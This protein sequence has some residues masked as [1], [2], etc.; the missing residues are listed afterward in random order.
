MS[1]HTGAII[2]AI[3]GG[4]LAA[5][6]GMGAGT[7][8]STPDRNIGASLITGGST[9]AGGI[10]LSLPFALVSS[11]PAAFVCAGVAALIGVTIGALRKRG[12]RGYIE[13]GI[14]LAAAAVV[15]ISAGVLLG[16]SA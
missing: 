13:T 3:I 10:S 15:T 16:G 11:R 4:T 14:I 2:P 9:A 8:L 1:G 7:W 12:R 6:V 5:S